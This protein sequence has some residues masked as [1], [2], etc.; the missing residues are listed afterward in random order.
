MPPEGP[1]IPPWSL[2]PS[3]PDDVLQEGVAGGPCG[4][5][6]SQEYAG[7][8]G[9]EPLQESG[10]PGAGPLQESIE[11]GG[12]LQ[13]SLPPGAP[14]D[15]GGPMEFIPPGGSME[16]MPAGGGRMDCPPMESI[17]AGGGGRIDCV[18]G[19]PM[20]S[21][22]PNAL[23][24][25]PGGSLQEL[26]PPGAPIEFIGLGTAVEPGGPP[27]LKPPGGPPELKPPGAM[28]GGPIGAMP[29]PL[30]ELSMPHPPTPFPKSGG[31]TNLA[32]I[33]GLKSG[34]PGRGGI[35]IPFPPNAGCGGMGCESL[36]VA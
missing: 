29:L 3:F 10:P 7:G 8:A 25:P 28:P 6:V 36:N 19:A 16:F 13:E 11:G 18:P 34:K 2:H 21:M 15:P 33:G 30:K 1:A 31:L 9:A 12:A 17:S 32:F 23:P 14:M 20:E 27:E 35:G 26:G 24:F 5:D 4:E 22:P